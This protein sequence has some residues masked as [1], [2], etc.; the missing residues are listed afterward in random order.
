MFSHSFIQSI[1]QSLFKIHSIILSLN[2]SII[3]PVGKKFALNI[4]YNLAIIL[5][6][7]GVVWCYNNH[8][9]LPGAFL[10]GVAACL[11]YFKVQL[12]KEI[13][14]TYRGKDQE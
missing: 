12:M 5:S 7:L 4:F 3:S 13:R 6:V 8:K 1:Y 2:N 14:K 10:V 11:L 9:Y